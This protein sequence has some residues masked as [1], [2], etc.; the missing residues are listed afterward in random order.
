M[1]VRLDLEGL[2]FHRRE[3]IAQ[4]AKAVVQ[5]SPCRSGLPSAGWRDQQDGS[6]RELKCG[7]MKKIEIAPEFLQF[8]G[9]VLL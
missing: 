3:L 1:R 2:Q 6:S 4:I 9:Q 8:Y 7:T 5:Q